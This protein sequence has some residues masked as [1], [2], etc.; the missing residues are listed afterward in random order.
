MSTPTMILYVKTGCPWCQIAEAYLNKHKYLYQS[1]DVRKD[2]V[3]FDLMKRLSHQT[4]TPTL[5]VGELLLADFGPDELE[6]FLKKNNL[7]P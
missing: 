1:V 6:E 2:R 7:L 5:V 4:Y 3:A